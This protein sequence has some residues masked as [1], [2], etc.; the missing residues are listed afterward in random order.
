[1]MAAKEIMVG[2]PTIALMMPYRMSFDIWPPFF[3]LAGLASRGAS[4]PGISRKSV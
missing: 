1:M 2:A 4:S 3:F